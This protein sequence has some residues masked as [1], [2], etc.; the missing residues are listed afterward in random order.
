MRRYLNRPDVRT[1][2]HALGNGRNKFEECA[3]PPYNALAHQDG[4]SAAP[5]LAHIL[6]KGMRVLVYSG[7]YDMVRAAAA[8]WHT[9]KILSYSFQMT[10]EG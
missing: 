8:R 10:V 5:A 4:L 3:D 9:I 6:D 2:L 1:A 7:Q